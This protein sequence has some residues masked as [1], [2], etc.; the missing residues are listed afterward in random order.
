MSEK[1]A[2]IE[3][4][5]TF[6]LANPVCTTVI[7]VTAIIT[8][9]TVYVVREYINKDSKNKDEDRDVDNNRRGKIRKS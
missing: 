6:A 9:G 1:I 5:K 8:V 3:A 2:F 7:V 4:C